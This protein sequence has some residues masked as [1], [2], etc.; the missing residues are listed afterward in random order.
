MEDPAIDVHVSTLHNLRCEEVMLLELN[1]WS[2]VFGLHVI[3]NVDVDILDDDFE[4]GEG[5]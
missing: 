3:C 1:V 5:V 2:L 4:S